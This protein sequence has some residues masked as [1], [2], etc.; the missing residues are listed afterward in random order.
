[1]NAIDSMMATLAV[2]VAVSNSRYDVLAVF[3]VWAIAA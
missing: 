2:I 3:G 1:L